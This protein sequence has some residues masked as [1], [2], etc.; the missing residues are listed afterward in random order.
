MLK[1]PLAR[2]GSTLGWRQVASFSLSARATHSGTARVV[3]QTSV[4]SM[5]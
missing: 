4:C 5:A 2:K 3:V 1:N